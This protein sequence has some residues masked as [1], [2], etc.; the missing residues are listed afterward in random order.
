[1]I[2]R[3]DRR[4]PLARRR[5][6][7]DS[8]EPEVLFS[9]I[10]HTLRRTLHESPE[11]SGA[12]EMTA[13]IITSFLSAY[14]PTELI[15]GLGGHGVAATWDSG[16][17]G[18]TVLI[19][20]ELDALQAEGVGTNSLDLEEET[21]PQVAHLCGHDGHM[22]MVAGLAPLL[23]VRPPERGRVVLL[24]QP[25]EENGEGALAVIGDP[26][27]PR[28]TPTV[29]MALHNLPGLP[30]RQ[31]LVRDG[32]F[33]CASVGMRIALE[34]FSSHAAEPENARTPATVISRL[35]TELP[36]L[37]TE[38]ETYRL[39]TITHARMGRPTFG[40]TPGQGEL[41]ATLRAV[42]DEILTDLRDEATRL[43][44]AAA[45]AEG[46]GVEIEWIE[47]FPATVNDAGL[48]DR[49]ERVGR[50]E[51][52]DVQRA[53]VAFRWSED[54]GHFGKVCPI[55]MFGYGIGERVPAL[56]HPEYQFPDTVVEA[57][58]ALWNALRHA[59]EERAVV[60]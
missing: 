15:T 37:K 7:I 13:R 9:G 18:P 24:F 33:A 22:A 36:A 41:F 52:F 58:A 31:V 2:D 49:V 42:R 60:S 19:R 53:E 54:F 21:L 57:G 25:A 40:V 6:S 3:P 26:Q 59:L 35:L 12:E 51:G 47:E 20:C 48:V 50:E 32:T 23:R 5:R 45:D 30:A 56:H 28:I 38:G 27:F 39:V 29:A 55:V 46:I 4:P 1:M 16:T 14:A 34:G 11:P 43:V 10:L 17:R 44:H 8:P